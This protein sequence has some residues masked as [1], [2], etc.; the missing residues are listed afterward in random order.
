[1]TLL[2]LLGCWLLLATVTA[3]LFVA[4][5]R[6]GEATGLAQDAVGRPTP[7]SAPQLPALPQQRGAAD[8]AVV[9]TLT[10]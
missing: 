9:P 2:L 4:V 1:M 3:A 10:T 5:V 6:G 8:D 7:V